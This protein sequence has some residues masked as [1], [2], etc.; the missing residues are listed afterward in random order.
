[1]TTAADGQD[2][3]MRLEHEV[4]TPK[5][6]LL[7]DAFLPPPEAIPSALRRPAV[8]R[9]APEPAPEPTP[10]PDFAATMTGAQ[11]RADEGPEDPPAPPPRRRPVRRAAE[12]EKSLEEEI[13]DFMSRSNRALAPDTEPDGS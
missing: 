2:L 8:P 11:R 13:A 4:R 12:P 5:E 10:D 3:F 6:R 1:M 7:V 9:P